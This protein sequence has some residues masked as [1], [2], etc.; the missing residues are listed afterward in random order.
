[1]WNSRPIFNK[2]SAPRL[3]TIYGGRLK[4]FRVTA[5]KFVE[6]FSEKLPR[7]ARKAWTGNLSLTPVRR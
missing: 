3:A 6:N 2:L 1:M 7:R 4:A 5:E